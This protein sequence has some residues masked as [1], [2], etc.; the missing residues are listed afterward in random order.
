MKSESLYR[1]V[2]VVLLAG[3]L[4]VQLT[5]LLKTTAHTKDGI[6]IVSITGNVGVDVQNSVE[7][8]TKPFVP[9]EVDH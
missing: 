3:I 2:V 1:I 6:P 7:V 8:H 5:N 4:T 9:L